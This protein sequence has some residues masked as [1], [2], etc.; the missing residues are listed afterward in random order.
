M[1]EEPLDPV[2]RQY[3]EYMKEVLPV[4][5]LEV[6]EIQRKTLGDGETISASVVRKLYKSRKFED[7]K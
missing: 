7:M 1:A 4:F 3:N 6:E 2:T 5:G